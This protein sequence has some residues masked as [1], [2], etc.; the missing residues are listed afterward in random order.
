VCALL[1]KTVRRLLPTPI[2]HRGVEI[3]DVFALGYGL[4]YAG[5]YRNLEFVV[6]GD[7]AVLAGDPDA[8]LAQLYRRSRP[9]TLGASAPPL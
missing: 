8:Y 1:D 7:L 4:D 5:R 3:P 9:S 6:A 2:R